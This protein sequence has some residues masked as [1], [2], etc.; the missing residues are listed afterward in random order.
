MWKKILCVILSLAMLFSITGCNREE[1]KK[2]EYQ[3]YYLNM[4]M[5]KIVAEEYNSTGA[6]GADLVEELLLKLQ[7]AP[8]STKLRQTIP[9]N[10]KVN[11]FKINGAYLY[12]DFSEEYMKLKPEEE[13]LIRASIV[14]TLAQA[15]VCLLYAFTVNSEPL[16]THDG[17]LV[18]SMSADS[19]VENPGKQINSSVETT[20]NLYFSNKDGTKLVKET[21]TVHYSTNISMEKLIMEQLIEGPK[22]SGTMST[23]PSGTKLISVSV[24]DGV[25]Y[26]NLSD[27]FKNNQNPEVT[28]EVVLYSIVNSLTEL[29]GV[30]KVQIS[31]NGS[32]DGDIRY[33]YDLSKMYERDLKLVKED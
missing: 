23:V 26:V 24:V 4:D 28:E 1:Q 21:R 7:S 14:K 18:G 20:L 13:I 10:V 15:N 27:S 16:L 5:S 2:G 31:I 25:C 17:T 32:T 29:Q 12:V 9:T 30:S 6:T 11:S 33:S 19:F 22:K 3:I 8:D